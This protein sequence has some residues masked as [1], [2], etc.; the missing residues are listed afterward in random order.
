MRAVLLLRWGLS[1]GS[2]LSDTW[3]K[4]ARVRADMSSQELSANTPYVE[5]PWF[6]IFLIG[7]K[8]NT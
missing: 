3:K 8:P 2:G 7:D 4:M 5:V 6:F 1:C